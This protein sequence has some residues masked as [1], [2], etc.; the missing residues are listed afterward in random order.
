MRGRAV[1]SAPV[2]NGE[3]IQNSARVKVCPFGKI[4]DVKGVYG[5]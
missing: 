1:C 5:I 2:I 4:E 3:A